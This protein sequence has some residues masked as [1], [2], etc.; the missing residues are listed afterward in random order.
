MLAAAFFFGLVV[1]L[2]GFLVFAPK[3]KREDGYVRLASIDPTA[4]SPKVPGA[5][6]A[7]VLLLFLAFLVYVALKH[8]S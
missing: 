7:A 2:C 6:V 8:H 4:G 1:L 5:T 3:Q